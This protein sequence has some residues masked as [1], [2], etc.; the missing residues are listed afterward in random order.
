MMQNHAH[1]SSSGDIRTSPAQSIIR[2]ADNA[3]ADSQLL[4]LLN[5]QSRRSS[6]AEEASGVLHTSQHR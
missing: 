2:T 3:I 6:L 5:G 4:R 1:L